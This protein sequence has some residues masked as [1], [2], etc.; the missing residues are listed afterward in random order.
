MD[1]IAVV[2]VVLLLVASIAVGAA[3]DC[4]TGS[5]D[6]SSFEGAPGLM[7]DHTSKKRT[8]KSSGGGTALGVRAGRGGTIGESEG[9]RGARD[10]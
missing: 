6:G 5:T 1:S 7:A 4:T 10:C 3:N 9:E 2:A 8:A